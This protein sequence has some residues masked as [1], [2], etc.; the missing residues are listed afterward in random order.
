MLCISRGERHSYMCIAVERH[1][2]GQDEYSHHKWAALGTRARTTADEGKVTFFVFFCGMPLSPTPQKTHS[3]GSAANP[4]WPNE[5][6]WNPPSRERAKRQHEKKQHTNLNF[7]IARPF[8]MITGRTTAATRH[9]SDVRTTA[10]D[11][12]ERTTADA[13]RKE[14]SPKNSSKSNMYNKKQV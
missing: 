13:N 2:K 1:T 4:A 7:H 5:H 9:K 11:E 3:R 8:M 10:G 14:K 6:G 12:S